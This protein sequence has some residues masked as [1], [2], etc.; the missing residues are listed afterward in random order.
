[1][2]AEKGSEEKTAN[3]LFSTQKEKF[4]FSNTHS[5]S[6]TIQIKVS[7]IHRDIEKQKTVVVEEEK[8]IFDK[9]VRPTKM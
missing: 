8:N 2:C 4:C 6:H 5:Q 7:K 3:I 9:I 1:M